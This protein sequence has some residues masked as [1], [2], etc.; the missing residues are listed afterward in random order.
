MTY[1]ITLFTKKYKRTCAA[2]VLLAISVVLGLI[3]TGYGMQQAKKGWAAADLQ[4]SR[5]QSRNVA[6]ESSVDKLKSYLVG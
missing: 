4:L 6:I 5:V 3:G 2:V 1:Q